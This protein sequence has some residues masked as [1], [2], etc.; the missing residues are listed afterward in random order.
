[1]GKGSPKFGSGWSPGRWIGESGHGGAGARQPDNLNRPTPPRAGSGRATVERDRWY[2]FAPGTTLTLS[3]GTEDGTPRSVGAWACSLRADH[4]LVITPG[5]VETG[6]MVSV[7]LETIRSGRVDHPG[8]VESSVRIAPGEHRTLVRFE[9]RIELT[10][11]PVCW[12]VA[13]GTDGTIHEIT[14]QRVRRS[15]RPDRPGHEPPR[16]VARMERA[17]NIITVSTEL[18]RRAGEGAGDVELREL[19][20]LINV[21]L[22]EQGPQRQPGADRAA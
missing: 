22:E 18:A 2:P 16:D 15:A 9:R 4:V 14:E 17:A 6:A 1:M 10:D 19:A 11:Y 21:L 7:P 5:T 8:T 20:A 3:I 12:G 13:F